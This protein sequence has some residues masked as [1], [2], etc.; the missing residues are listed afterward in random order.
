MMEKQDSNINKPMKI[1]KKVDEK[2]VADKFTCSI[3]NKKMNKWKAA[4]EN[5]IFWVVNHSQV[6]NWS[7]SR[8]LGFKM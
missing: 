5:G 3:S 4:K 6:L 7:L 1:M 8:F 2:T